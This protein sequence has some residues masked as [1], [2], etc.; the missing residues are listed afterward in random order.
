MSGPDR[1]M[2]MASGAGFRRFAM[3]AIAFVCTFGTIVCMAGPSRPQ[4][5]VT[6]QDIARL[7]G[8]HQSTVSR[9]LSG[10][11]RI[12]QETIQKVQAACDEL[13]YVPNAM[14]RS[15][16]TRRPMAI[17]VHIPLDTATTTAD[18]FVPVFLAA[19]GQEAARHGYG[20]MLPVPAGDDAG[21]DQPA[22]PLPG[23][24]EGLVR[25][26]RV[27]GVVITTPRHDDPRVRL[28]NQHQIPAVFGRF[29]AKLGPLSSCVDIDNVDK[30]VQIASFLLKRGHRRIGVVG[31]PAGWLPGE[32]L[33]KGFTRRMS[34]ARVPIHPA[35]RKCAAVTFEGAFQAATQLLDSYPKLTALVA[36]TALTLFGVLQAVNRSGRRVQV[37]GPDSPLL[38]KLYP[39]LAR[40]ELPIDALG[41]AMAHG[42]IRTIES[43]KTQPTHFLQVRILDEQGQPFDSQE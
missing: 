33:W 22:Q 9:V 32:D 35:W 34:Q 24:L 4:P 28:L 23:D 8:V 15:L 26:G 2:A 41:R 30:G 36:G 13:G 16:R 6:A 10:F 29:D 20:L 19:V 42:L 11:P 17:A 7:A 31:E 43:G 5:S 21:Q 18:P 12:R 40:M 37:L 25:G 3:I 1:S 14:A 38:S 39:D 27:D